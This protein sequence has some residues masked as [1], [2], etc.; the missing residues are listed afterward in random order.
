MKSIEVSFYVSLPD[1][2]EVKLSQKPFVEME[3]KSMMD[4]NGNPVKSPLTLVCV[5]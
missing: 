2:T 5:N 1:K 4:M 3:I